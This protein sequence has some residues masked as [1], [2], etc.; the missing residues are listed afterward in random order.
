[1]PQMTRGFTPPGSGGQSKQATFAGTADDAYAQAV[2]AIQAT[3]GELNWQ[4][5]PAG[6]KFML[7]RKNIWSTAGF[8]LR[9]DGD[10]QVSPAGP[11]QVTARFALKLQWGSAVPLLVLQVLGVVVAAMFNI[12]FAYFALILIVVFLAATAWTASSHIPEKALEEIIKNLQGGAPA[13]HTF[14]PPPQPF[15]PP[16]QPQPHQP[17]QQQQQAPAASTAAPSAPRADSNAIMEQIKQLAGLRDAGA[18]TPAEF[19]AKKAELLSRI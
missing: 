5:P 3:G 1:M 10:L 18:I 16:P 9:Y 14:A 11:G 7:P 13:P 4:Q 19:E 17:A 2:R 12:Y 8:T 6:A 15:N